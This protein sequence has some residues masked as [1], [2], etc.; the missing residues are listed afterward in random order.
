[1][2]FVAWGQ[3]ALADT[4]WA[5]P[6]GGS[7]FTASNW[8]NGVP[9]TG[10]VVL[11]NSGI[12]DVGSNAATAQTQQLILGGTNIGGGLAALGLGNNNLS[13]S[14]I[15][16]GRDSG[17]NGFATVGTNGFIST[18]SFTLGQS[19]TGTLSLSSNGDSNFN[20]K[21][22][23]GEFA[24]SS[25]TV[26][27]NG[28]IF[29]CLS[30]LD[31]TDVALAGSASITVSN[32]GTFSALSFQGTD[33]GKNGGIAAFTVSGANSEV[34]TAALRVHSA[35]TFDIRNGGVVDA[36]FLT[37]DGGI[38]TIGV[39]GQLLVADTIFLS[40]AS[41]ITLEI[42]GVAA[43]QS[44]LIDSD[45]LVLNGTMTV[46]L[47]NGFQPMLGNSF[48]VFT[49]ASLGAFDSLNLPALSPGLSWDSSLIH[50][51]GT[52]TVVPE[53]S[54]SILFLAAMAALLGQRKRL[55]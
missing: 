4:D 48:S 22:I 30:F 55:A 9:D 8:T 5:G 51:N 53:P 42:G 47:A 46:V 33:V 10:D 6:P 41:Q 1:M 32:G 35:S 37:D 15:V 36:A 23:I 2:L 40:D 18:P 50:S 12:V 20:G 13:G 29:S 44:G 7:W 16:I 45:S 25:G 28:G 34:V 14:S 31:T 27:A 24:G 43:N 54:T 26:L 3:P 49:G 17:S 52:I 38:W 39:G 19:G 21:V 11:I